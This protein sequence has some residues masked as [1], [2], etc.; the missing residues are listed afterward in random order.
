MKYA[1]VGPDGRIL[2]MS[3]HPIAGFPSIGVLT[4][5]VNDLTH[6]SVDGLLFPFPEQPSPSH[7]WDW[8]TKTWADVRTI[9]Q[10]RE[11]K[12]DQFKAARTALFNAPMQTPYGL[13]DS[14]PQSRA[15]IESTVVLLQSMANIGQPGTVNFVLFDN[16]R[17]ELGLEEMVNVGLMLGAKIQQGFNIAG[18]LRDALDAATTIEEVQAINWPV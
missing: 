10:V 11:D 13:F 7:T 14:D 18:D 9:E 12:W 5:G 3:S 2:Q 17:V 8:A 16:S 15:F 4:D 6:Y 1:I